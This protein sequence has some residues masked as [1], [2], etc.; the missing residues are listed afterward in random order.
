MTKLGICCTKI[1]QA[2]IP[3]DKWRP[4]AYVCTSFGNNQYQTYFNNII[5]P[6]TCYLMITIIKI[7]KNNYIIKYNYHT[8][9]LC[10]LV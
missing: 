9:T 10:V 8:I 2:T 1:S 5:D 3:D 7:F 4:P 6:R